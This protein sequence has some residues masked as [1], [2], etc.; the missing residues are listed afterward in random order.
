[1]NATQERVVR[2]PRPCWSGSRPRTHYGVYGVSG[3]YGKSTPC[4]SLVRTHDRTHDLVN[5]LWQ[6][7]LLIAF[8]V[9]IAAGVVPLPLN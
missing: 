3:V 9:A 4:A 8:L 6:S 2:S 7:A 5:G 1:M